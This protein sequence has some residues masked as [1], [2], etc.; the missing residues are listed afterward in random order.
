MELIIEKQTSLELYVTSKEAYKKWEASPDEVKL[1]D[2]RTPEE[3]IFIGHPKM[4]WKIPLGAQSYVWDDKE[5]KFPMNLLTDFVDRVKEIAKT[6]ELL[7]MM[8]RS[9]VRSAMAVN[10]LAQAGFTNVFNVTDGMEGDKVSDPE[11][12]FMGQRMKNGWKNSGCPW[13]YDLTLDR[14]LLSKVSK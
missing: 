2:V 9:G 13:T 8:C 7:M 12:V 6:D 10:L 3:M 5:E 14:M 4:A 1:I 11:S